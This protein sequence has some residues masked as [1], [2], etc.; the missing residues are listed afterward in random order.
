MFVKEGR[1]ISTRARNRKKFYDALEHVSAWVHGGNKHFGIRESEQLRVEK[2]NLKK[3]DLWVTFTF[4]LWE[5][6]PI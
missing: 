1:N 4:H 5:L 2:L 6:L 3:V